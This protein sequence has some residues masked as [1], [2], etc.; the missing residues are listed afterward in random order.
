[1]ASNQLE[2]NDSPYLAMHGQDPVEWEL[3]SKAVLDRAVRENKLIF[4]SIGYFSCHWCH[5]MQR[6]SYQNVD[7]AKQLNKH[8]IPVKIDRELN[9]DLDAYLIDFVTRTRGAAGWPLNV[10]LT[11]AG[12]PLVGFTYLPAD[13]FIALLQDLQQQWQQDPDYFRQAAARAAQSM[14]GQ[15]LAAESSLSTDL[16]IRYES[17]YMN[18]A[19]G[20]ADEMSGGFGEESKFPMVPQLES[21]LD[22]YQRNPHQEVKKFLTLTLDNMASMGMRDHLGGGFFRYTVDPGW[23]TPHFEKMLYDNAL[24]ATLYLRAAKVLEKPEYEIVGRETLDFMVSEMAGKNGAMISS[25]SAIDDSN[26][27]GGYYLWKQE[28][29]LGLL[30][31][32][33]L[34][35]VNSLWG[36][37]GQEDLEAGHLPRVNAPLDEVANSVHMDI[38]KAKAVMSSARKKL[39]KARAKRVLPVDDKYIAALNGLAL[40]ALIEGSKLSDGKKYLAAANKIHSYLVNELW[41]GKRLLRAKGKSGELGTAGLEDYAF[42][43]QAL[44]NWSKLSSKG[45]LDENDDF[46]L[47]KRLVNDAWQRFHDKTGWRLSDQTLFPGS[48]GMPMLEEGSLPSPSAVLVSASMKIA[49]YANDKVLMLKIGESL[50]MGH[51][52]LS[53]DAFF[54]P[55]QVSLLVRYFLEK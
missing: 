35:L 52:R 15:P 29:L 22:A 28:S 2:G 23:H 10:F 48:Y 6:E 43:A 9:P 39:L 13:R 38:E 49:R 34:A 30:T 33:E 11:P 50:E 8:F 51:S 46:I 18:Q 12:N 44:L 21:M 4:V 45:K 41:D 32:E 7:V 3:W 40:S 14:K 31:P 5:V 36:M 20:L 47:A 26:I 37:Q 53:E 27:E 16:T 42:V 24:L 54:H 1:M 17:A 55:S 19:M 25:F